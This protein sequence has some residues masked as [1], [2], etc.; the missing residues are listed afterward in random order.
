LAYSLDD[1]H[2]PKL[3][4]TEQVKMMILKEFYQW[5]VIDLDKTQIKLVGQA[6]RSVI[7]K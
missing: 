4:M 7:N 3:K 1:D 5:E 6:F 2:A